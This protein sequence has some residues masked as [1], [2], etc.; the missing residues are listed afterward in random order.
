MS[1]RVIGIRKVAGEQEAQLL[2]DGWTKR[3]TIDEPRLSELVETYAALGYEVKVLEP[4][5][6]GEC[7]ACIEEAPSRNYATIW[8]RKRAG[9]NAGPDELL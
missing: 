9:A 7:T 2:A 3:T 6:G 5:G 1:A 4:N 8:L